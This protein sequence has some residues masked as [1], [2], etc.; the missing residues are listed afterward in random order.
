MPPGKGP[1]DIVGAAISRDDHVYV[2]YRDGTVSGGTSDDLDRYRA[3]YAYTLPPGRGPGDVVG[4]AIA[5]SDD[6]AYAWYRDGTAS[7]GTTNDLDRHRRAYAYTTDARPPRA[8][9]NLRVTDPQL[10][11]LTLR[12]RD[13]STCESRQH[14]EH[15][16]DGG[17]GWR[18]V[19]TTEPNVTSRK[20]SRLTRATEHCFR[21]KAW[22]HA[23]ASVWSNVACGR[24]RSA[25]NGG[26][27]PQ[28]SVCCSEDVP[29]GWI[30]VDD[31]W[32]PTSCGNPTSETFNRCVLQQY[33][34]VGR[35][36]TLDVCA[37]APVP[38]DWEEVGSHRDGRKCGHPGPQFPAH[39]VK[40]I[41]RLR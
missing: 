35:G 18:E 38:P 37:S 11:E 8:P 26:S 23:G 5:C 33:T 36:G 39:N 21:V 40:T 22:S 31:T 1:R 7:A 2:W 14:I 13:N 29:A 3:P 24:T 19:A 10:T 25:T 34:V 28:K 15:S 41:R 16:P 17:D 12:W 32:S 9:S 4:L 30:K 20:M 6:H 27:I